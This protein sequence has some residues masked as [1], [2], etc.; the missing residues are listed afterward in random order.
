MI[1]LAVG[2]AW[3]LFGDKLPGPAAFWKSEKPYYVVHLTNG[4]IYYGQ[5]MSADDSTIKMADVYYFESYKEAQSVATSQNYALQG[6]E[7]TIFRLVRRGTDKPA[8]TDH[9]LYVNRSAVLFWE[10]LADDS[11]MM[12][13]IAKAGEQK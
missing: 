4:Q 13:M 11:D 2:G 8:T 7:Q 12:K 6:Q 9:D 10:K 5:I 3:K 1:I